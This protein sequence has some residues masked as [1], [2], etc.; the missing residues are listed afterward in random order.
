[1]GFDSNI[2]KTL[3]IIGTINYIGGLLIYKEVILGDLSDIRRLAFAITGAGLLIFSGIL[4][5][6][7]FKIDSTI[8]HGA[9]NAITQIYNRVAEQLS[10]SDP[11]KAKVIMN[12]L[13]DA[14]KAI[15]QIRN[16]RIKS[17]QD[18]KYLNTLT[19]QKQSKAR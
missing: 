18:N 7:A 13:K 8:A 9:L 19:T 12:G 1:M 5:Y 10:K 11:K 4:G 6:L 3:G 15:L 17:D 2:A 14:P 16:N